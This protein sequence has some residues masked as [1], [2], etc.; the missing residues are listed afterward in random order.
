V[1]GSHRIEVPGPDRGSPARNGK[2]GDVERAGEPGHPLEQV[3][4]AREVDA[5][6]PGDDEA[7]RRGGPEHESRAAVLCRRRVDEDASDTNLVADVDLAHVGEPAQQPAGSYG[8]DDGDVGAELAQR[9][10]VEV[11]VVDVRDQHG[12]DAGEARGLHRDAAAQVPDAG[13]QDGVCQQTD[14]VQLDQ[15]GRMP[16]VLQPGGVSSYLTPASSGPYADRA[17]ITSTSS[18]MIRIAQTG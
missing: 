9:G 18:A 13:P 11:V 3:G 10:A 7:E 16:D 2:Q 1:S 17:A 12:I 8:D 15:D 5:P 14:P 6:R 4:V